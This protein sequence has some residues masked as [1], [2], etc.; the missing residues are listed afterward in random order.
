MNNAPGPKKYHELK[1]WPEQFGAIQA[2][3]KT[4]EFRKND[5]NFEY[6]DAVL[7][8]EWDQFAVDG[9]NGYT[10]KSIPVRITYILTS[11]FG[12]PEGYCVFSFKMVQRYA[13]MPWDYRVRKIQNAEDQAIRKS[14]E[15]SE[16]YPW[17]KFHLIYTD[18]ET[19]FTVDTSD[20]CNPGETLL[21]TW[22]NGVPIYVTENLNFTDKQPYANFKILAKPPIQ[23]IDG[24]P[25]A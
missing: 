18:F 12:I 13:M 20:R 22:M 5:R 11:G 24:G 17:Q 10:G 4:F 8:R 6:G 16:Q 21:V 2:G 1:V 14:R 7:L 25:I 15:L 19:M 3:T 23:S 9:Y